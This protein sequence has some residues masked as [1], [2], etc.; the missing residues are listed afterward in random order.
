MSSFYYQDFKGRSIWLILSRWLK[1]CLVVFREQ[2]SV[3]TKTRNNLKPPKTIWNQ[4]KPATLQHFLLKISYAQVEFILILRH[5]VFFRQIW[6]QKLRF[7]KLTQNWYRDTLLYP[8]FEFNV[9]FSK[10]FDTHF[11]GQIWSQNLKLIK[12]SKNWYRS[13]L[14]HAYYSF[15]VYSFKIF[16]FHLF[17]TNLVPK[18]EVLKINW[19][20]LQGYIAI[21]ML[22]TILMFI[23]AK[24]LSLMYFCQI[25]SHNLD[26]FKLTEIS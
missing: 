6:S 18:S 20:L 13:R 5:K 10:I 3:L 23:F 14:L 2:M 1:Y 21:Y 9:Y 25:W 16:V 15:N 26:L 17:W 12:F 7:S 24:S 11:F 4:L 8:Y 19:N 22:I